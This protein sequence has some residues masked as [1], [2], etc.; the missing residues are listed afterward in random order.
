MKQ[1]LRQPSQPS[2]TLLQARR[3]PEPSHRSGKGRAARWS[4]GKRA[5]PAFRALGFHKPGA[6]QLNSMGRTQGCQL[7]QP[8]KGNLKK[9]LPAEYS[10]VYNQPPVT[11]LFVPSPRQRLHS[12]SLKTKKPPTFHSRD[13][14][15]GSPNP[16]APA[17]GTGCS[18]LA[19]RGKPPAGATRNL[20][21]EARPPTAGPALTPQGPHFY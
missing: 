15:L 14:G 21:E 20:P 16:P 5:L 13:L 11:D 6:A 18:H 9:V 4:C 2:P 17:G 7:P 19:S 8:N 1:A 12:T 3:A 10:G